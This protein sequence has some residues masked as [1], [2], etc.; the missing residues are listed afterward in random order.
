VAWRT[1]VGVVGDTK[2][3]DVTLPPNPQLYLP[4]SQDPARAMAF[5]MRAADAASL[6]GA[7]R[8]AIR[9]VDSAL[10]VYELRTM[11]E[12]FTEEMSSS[13]I[14]TSLY[15][16]FAVIAVLLAAAGLYGVISYSVSQR[17]Q[18]IGVRVALGAVPRDVQRMVIGQ[19]GRLIA[20]GAAIG[21]VASLAIAEAMRSILYGVSPLDPVT[22]ST[23]LG[24]LAV[25]MLA[26]TYVPARRAMRIDPIRALREN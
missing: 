21:L 20:I 10:A 6:S 22:Y 13:Y 15:V 9:D 19:A 12:A 23:V 24:V 8:A 7:V 1:I 11:E 14:L 18:E 25:V 17:T 5:T 16:A 3:A 2:P 26:A 4:L